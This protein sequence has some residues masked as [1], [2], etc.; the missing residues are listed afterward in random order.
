LGAVERLSESA[1]LST[2]PQGA[3]IVVDPTRLVHSKQVK[4]I[5]F[6]QWMKS[7]LAPQ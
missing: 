2:C 3:I 1:C 6:A 5:A 7:E 4:I